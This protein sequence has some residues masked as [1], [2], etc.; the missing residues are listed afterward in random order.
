MR[1]LI[2]LGMILTISISGAVAN[3]QTPGRD[4]VLKGIEQC[5]AISVDFMRAACLDA[6]N[7]FLEGDTAAITSPVDAEA[8]RAALAQERAEIDKARAELDAKA[9]TQSANERLGLLTRLGLARNT[10]QD[11]EN[12]AAIITIERVTYN[13]KKIHRFFTSDGDIIIQD[14]RSLSMRLPD[15]FPATATL[16]KRSLGSKWLTFTDI[17]NRTYRVKIIDPSG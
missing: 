4:D 17:P 12:L 15:T 3:A 5:G 7:R 13:R 1:I 6:G 11:D 16:E 8:E 14:A 10:E 9:Q 2:F